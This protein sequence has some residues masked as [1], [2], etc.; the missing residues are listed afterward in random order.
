MTEHGKALPR[1]YDELNSSHL[2]IHGAAD[3]AIAAG[4]AVVNVSETFLSPGRNKADLGANPPVITAHNQPAA[5]IRVIEKLLEI[6]RRTQ[7]GAEGFDALGIIVIKLANDKSKVE[8]V[9]DHPARPSNDPFSYGQ[10]IHRI[11]SL[12]SIKFANI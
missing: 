10:M 1:L 3:F 2:V 4:L 9:H 5:A 12:Y 11:A 6:P 8:I 7:Q